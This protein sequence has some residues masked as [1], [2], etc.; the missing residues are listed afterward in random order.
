MKLNIQ[1]GCIKQSFDQTI[2][3][4]LVELPVFSIGTFSELN[5]LTQLVSYIKRKFDNR[6]MLEI[7]LSS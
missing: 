5:F 6:V 1:I 4:K 7:K 2:Y 3:F